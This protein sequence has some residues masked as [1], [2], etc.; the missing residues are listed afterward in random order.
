MM[1]SFPILASVIIV[2]AGLHTGSVSISEFA[3][4]HTANAQNAANTTSNTS[5][6]TAKMHLEEGI[7]LLKA[8]DKDSAMTHLSAAQAAMGGASSNAKMHFEE[9]MKALQAG[10]TN[11]A[12]THLTAADQALH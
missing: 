4:V 10:D 12:I 5:T 8:G 6:S 1:L 11:G 3:A 7:K 9:G 2:I